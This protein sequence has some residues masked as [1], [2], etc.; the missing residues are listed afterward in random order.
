MKQEVLEKME[1]SE[2]KLLPKK[3]KNDKSLKDLCG[4]KK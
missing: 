1:N 2:L 3:W 4:L